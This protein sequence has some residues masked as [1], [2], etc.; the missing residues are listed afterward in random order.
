M[1]VLTFNQIQFNPIQQDNQ[2]WL[3][4]SELAK[5]LGYKRADS[6]SRLYSRNSDEFTTNMTQVIDNPRNVNL[7]LRIF[8]LR[9]A[10]LIAMFANTDVAKEFR[11]WVLDILD[12]E[13]QA[14]QTLRFSR[15]TLKIASLI[16]TD[17]LFTS[18]HE[19]SSWHVTVR[20]V[21]NVGEEVRINKLRNDEY[22]INIVELTNRFEKLYDFMIGGEILSLGRYLR[23]QQKK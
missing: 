4:S 17:L 23:Q 20:P 9:G 16:E 21:H 10:H 2:I 15:T 19:A 14:K 18:P 22:P 8:S 11:K 7:A 1:N 12:K 13:I 5:A 6:I 3:T